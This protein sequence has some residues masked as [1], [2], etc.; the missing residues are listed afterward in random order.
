MAVVAGLCSLWVVGMI[1]PTANLFDP[2]VMNWY[3]VLVI[4]VSMGIIAVMMITMRCLHPPAAASALIAAM[5]YL[6][7]S[8]QVLGLIGAV[9]LLV[10]EAFLFN[11]IIGG[12]PYP[13]WRV[14]PKVAKN[15]GELAGIPGIGI[16]FWQ[17]LSNKIFQRR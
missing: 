13:M 14:D 3:R 11:R 9:M 2:S 4:M 5:G 10:L 17:Q 7:T 15:Y 16:T 8:V 6:E 1:Y 12:L